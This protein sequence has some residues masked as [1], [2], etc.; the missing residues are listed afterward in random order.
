MGDMDS[1]TLE[2]AKLRIMTLTSEN[3]N[4]R[5]EVEGL[6]LL[7]THSI[8]LVEEGQK[9]ATPSRR[10]IAGAKAFDDG[11]DAFARATKAKAL[12]AAAVVRTEAPVLAAKAKDAASK[13]RLG[14]FW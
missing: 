3:E 11:V 4:L 7:L 5:S 13:V 14:L 1:L 6:T 10:L 9:A 2:E 8:K 12:A